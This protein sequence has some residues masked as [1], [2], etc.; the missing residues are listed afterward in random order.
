MPAGYGAVMNTDYTKCPVA[1][2]L[3]TP[4]VSASSIS[5]FAM[6]PTPALALNLIMLTS[7]TAKA[8]PLHACRIWINTEHWE[9]TV[10][11]CADSACYGPTSKH[12][13]PKINLYLPDQI[14]QAGEGAQLS[15][16]LKGFQDVLL[17]L[18]L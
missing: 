14:L 15:L 9:C 2:L 16:G 10:P 6:V 1:Q 11:S 18:W 13:R 3:V 12:G 17:L 8:K 7:L 5:E 4:M